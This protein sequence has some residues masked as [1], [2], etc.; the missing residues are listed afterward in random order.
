MTSAPRTYINL[1]AWNRCNIQ[2]CKRNWHRIWT[3]N[4]ID[5]TYQ[6]FEGLLLICIPWPIYKCGVNDG[7]KMIFEDERLSFLKQI[8][9]MRNMREGVAFRTNSYMQQKQPRTTS[10]STCYVD[11]CIACVS[12]ATNFVPFLRRRNQLFSHINTYKMI[13]YKTD[14]DKKNHIKDGSQPNWSSSA[15]CLSALFI[16]SKTVYDGPIYHE[17]NGQNNELILLRLI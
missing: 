17:R 12:L 13:S 11:S 15:L 4:G 2:G 3:Q 14:P 6:Q 1:N 5:K 9:I 8:L 10:Y 16:L 7:K